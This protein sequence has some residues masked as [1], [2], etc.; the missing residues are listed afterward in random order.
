[1]RPRWLPT[2]SRRVF[3]LDSIAKSEPPL[4]GQ[5][6]R[7]SLIAHYGRTTKTRHV[8]RPTSRES[9]GKSA[10]TLS[11][12]TGWPV[13]IA[14]DI[15]DGWF[16]SV[17]VVQV[18]KA[19][20]LSP[21]A[22]DD[23]IDGLTTSL[24]ALADEEAIRMATL[25]LEALAFEWST[26]TA[27]S[28]AAAEERL[29]GIFANP[30]LELIGSQRIV[31]SDQIIETM[32]R[33]GAAMSRQ[34]G[35]GVGTGLR[36]PS[37]SAAEGLTRHHNFFVRDQYGRVSP[38]LA[39]QVRPIIEQG[40]RDGLGRE[41]IARELGASV[42]GGLQMR[43]YWET[44]ASNAMTQSRS[45]GIVSSLQRAAIQ[46]MRFE[47]LLDDR[48]TEICIALHGG[49]F[50]VGGAVAAMERQL[51]AQTPEAFMEAAPMTY[52]SGDKVVYGSGDDVTEV[53]RII[54][55]S[56]GGGVPGVYQGLQ[57]PGQLIDEGL[58]N[59]PLHHR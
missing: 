33:T 29:A 13:I 47:A 46:W 39:A 55:P 54:E 23:W 4:S 36:L 59:P 12:E 3:R 44:V 28:W 51:A 6:T 31:L 21:E 5:Q 52:V 48:T 30:S 56:P 58:G 8:Q 25:G 40:M 43:G 57:P 16:R 19:D 49:V 7:Y 11:N 18:V 32:N 20:P 41:A 37:R 26:A 42:R 9:V 17:G 53:M 27:F 15:G 35:V 10:S 22:L 2:D 1:M 24:T 50:P 14:E 38:G 34:P 45:M